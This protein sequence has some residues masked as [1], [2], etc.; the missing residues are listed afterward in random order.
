LRITN[1]WNYGGDQAIKNTTDTQLIQ[2]ALDGIT[3]R[4]KS[5]FQRL[6]KAR[7]DGVDTWKQA[8]SVALEIHV[9]GI[10]SSFQTRDRGRERRSVAYMK[11]YQIR[12]M[13]FCFPKYREIIGKSLTYRSLVRK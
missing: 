7:S 8:R 11:D 1:L 10:Q 5:G 12:T 6:N 9:K 4:R 2:K 3:Q 13:L